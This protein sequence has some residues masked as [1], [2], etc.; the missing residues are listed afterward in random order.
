MEYPVTSAETGLGRE[1]RNVY[2]GLDDLLPDIKYMLPRCDMEI[3]ARKT[4]AEVAQQFARVTGCFEYTVELTADGS[5]YRYELPVG[6]PADILF[7]K[8][9]RVYLTGAD[10]VEKYSRTLMT[11]TYSVEDPTEEDAAYLNLV[12][13]VASPDGSV[14]TLQVDV[15]LVP[16]F[17]QMLGTEAYALPDKWLRRWRSALVSGTIARLAG[18]RGRPWTDAE[19]SNA[20][21]LQYMTQEGEAK[22]KANFNHMK[23]GYVSSVNPIGFV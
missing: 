17:D 23:Q 12:S 16:H 3:T 9:V 7:V 20:M 8:E 10:G 19:L 15:A 13:P 1:D 22:A 5:A 2:R 4:L 18:M 11:H 21:Y 14:T 6:G